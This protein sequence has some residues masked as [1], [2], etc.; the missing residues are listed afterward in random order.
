MGL[1][2]RGPVWWMSFIVKGK[3]YR[4]STEGEDRKL[5]Q[6]IFDKVKGEIAE[7]KWFEDTARRG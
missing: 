3:R 4:R 5:A 6:R 7:G 1:Y 2:K